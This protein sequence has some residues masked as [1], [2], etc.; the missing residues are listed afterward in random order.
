MT[1]PENLVDEMNEALLRSTG[2]QEE[3]DDTPPELK[4]NSKDFLISK[5][6]E[7]ADKHQ[8]TLDLS[9]TK[10]RRMTKTQLNKL[11]AETIEK[12]M[13][14]QMAEQVGVSRG[15]TEKLIALGALRMIHNLCATGFEKVWN[16]VGS[17]YGTMWRALPRQSV[18]FCRVASSVF[19]SPPTKIHFWHK[20]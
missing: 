20:F 15:A 6:I 1:G 10:L 3:K 2:P 4:R 16:N 13:Q 19:R 9:N 11:L 12:G 17:K 8:I 14:Q 5:I 7:C 18:F